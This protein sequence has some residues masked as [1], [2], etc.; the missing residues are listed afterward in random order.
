MK[1][2]KLDLLTLLIGLFLFS[3]C[4]KDGTI[5][6]DVSSG[7]LINSVFTD[8]VTINSITVKDDSTITSSN[9]PAAFQT[10]FGFINDPEIGTT[11]ANLAIGLNLP[12][13]NFTFGNNPVL[14]SAVLALKYGDEFYGDSLSTYSI[15]VHQLTQ[16][17]NFSKA[18]YSSSN[19]AFTSPI[20]GI[21]TLSRIAWNGN[22]INDSVIINT[23]VQRGPDKSTRIA[24]HI[25][26]PLNGSF[27][28]NNFINTNSNNLKS[29]TAFNNFIKGLYVT[30]NKTQSTGTGGIIL[31]NAASLI[32]KLD[33]YYKTTTGIVTDTLLASFKVTAATEIKNARSTAVQTQL[34]TTNTSASFSTVYV[35]PLGGG[36]R[37]K[38]RFPYLA[39]LKEKGNISINKAEIVIPVL[40][41]TDV[42]PFKP[43][44]R[45]ALYRSD[46]A[47]QRQSVPDN[48]FTTFGGL[49]NA[50]EKTYTFNIT[51][52]IQDI[53]SNK[54]V[55]YDT[56]IAPIDLPLT[57]NLNIFSSA[58]TAARSV[59]GG[60][61]HPTNR[62]KLKLT[63]TKP[64]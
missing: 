41:N 21:K 51:S 25:R 27:I 57:Q 10:G 17:Y 55:Q 13:E 39:K 18:Y 64:N 46:I 1:Y 62:M 15:N 28:N 47:G 3:S 20:I 59:L 40:Q 50:T 44:P 45:L 31:I 58:T 63:Y 52:Y 11:E 9:F 61:N 6:L 54:L 36:L 16:P 5:G 34:N 8:T 49:Y 53:L 37:T 7:D 2:F 33:I 29:N 26:I 43:A 38:I 56:F 35:Q 12:L 48:N 23:I 30:V 4:K 42:F 32:S 22:N 14:D 24:P 19:S 60:G